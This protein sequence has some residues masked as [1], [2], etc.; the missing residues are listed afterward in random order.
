MQQAKMDNMLHYYPMDQHN[1]LV[2]HLIR[3]Y[4]CRYTSVFIPLYIFIYYSY[5]SNEKM[6]Y[7]D[8]MKQFII[9]VFSIITF[10]SFGLSCIIC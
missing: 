7:G 8:D 9:F 5:E 6:H 3:T 2:V 4:I 10:E 1:S